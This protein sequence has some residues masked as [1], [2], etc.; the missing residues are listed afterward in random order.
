[1]SNAAMLNYISVALGL[2][3]IVISLIVLLNLVIEG[4]IHTKI[5]RYFIAFILCNIGFVAADIIARLA[6]GRG[7]CLAFWLHR[8][9]NFIFFAL[10]P[11]LAGLMTLYLLAYIERNVR[12]PRTIRYTVISLCAPALVLTVASE[13]TYIFNYID[14]YN[15]YHRGAFF[16]VPQLFPVMGLALNGAVVIFYRRQLERLTIVFFVIYLSLPVI[17]LLAQ[18]PMMGITYINIAITLNLLI[19]YIR[20]QAEQRSIARAEKQHLVL[21]NRL[22]KESYESIK[23]HLHQ[24]GVLKHEIGKHLAAIQTYLN[25]GRHDEAVKYLDQI[26]AH[27]GLVSEA[28]YHSNFLI[29]AVVGNLVYKGEERGIKV[30][31]HLRAEPCGISDP[32]LYSLLNNILDNAMEACA[33]VPPSHKRYISLGLFRQDPYFVITCTNSRTGEI[34]LQTTKQGEGHGYG[35]RIIERIADTYDGLIDTDFGKDTF[36]IK[37]AIKDGA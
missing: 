33:A 31:L 5:T 25:D 10:G 13:F 24:V 26:G 6:M 19:I 2:F 27:A 36:T 18:I 8:G 23:T 4:D 35:L 1:M 28:V 32:D 17:A 7:G 37:V 15:R 3:C 11:F 9:A 22:A 14:E 29:N 34:T 21:Q 30:E 16:W 12:V 20:I